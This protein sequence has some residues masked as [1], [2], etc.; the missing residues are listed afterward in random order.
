MAQL[1]TIATIASTA[2]SVAQGVSQSSAQAKSARVQT[3]ALAA[4]AAER[5]RQRKE[6]VEKTVASTRARLSAS[7]AAPNSGSGE[8]LLDGI[9]AEAD[10]AQ[11]ADN[12]QLAAR[13]SAGR[14]SLLD[15]TGALTGFTRAVRGSASI[16]SGLRS[17]LD[18]F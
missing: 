10:A 2:A 14:R 12:Q 8:A 6:L 9:R 18:V 3:Q 16:G 15:E 7:G 13:I 11:D 5:A 17:L 1:A 4:Q